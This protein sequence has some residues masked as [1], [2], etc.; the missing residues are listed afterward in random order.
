M[1]MIGLGTER[2]GL[3]YFTNTR[4]ARCQMA[5][6]TFQL[7]HRRLGHLSNKVLSFLSNNVSDICSSDSEQCLVC[8][9]AKQTRIPFPTSQISSTASFE[10]IH[11]DIWGGYRTPSINGACYFLTIVD[12]YTRCTWVYLMQHKSEARSL[13]QSFINLVENQFSTTIKIIRS[14]NGLEFTIPSFYSDKGII[15]QTSCVSTPQQNGV[16]ERKHRHLLNM[17]RALLFQAHLPT[18]FWGDAILTTAYLI[19][20]TPT[21]LLFGKTPY[22]TLHNS[23]PQY[24]HLRVFGCLCFAS[25]HSHNPSKF[26]PRAIRC[27]FLGYPYSQK[28]YRLYNLD[29]HKT[30]ILR[31]VLF[32][33]DHFPFSQTT[34]KPSSPVLPIPFDLPND[35]TTHSSPIVEALVAPSTTQTTHSPPPITR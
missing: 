18:K 20:R 27:V 13:L 35:V 33:E 19:N 6:S 14:D 9:L 21:P 7:W 30:F 29:H 28:G 22:E 3:Y 15:H 31:D 16:V 2:D 10:L 26:A 1:K 4:P 11:I 24:N 8:P 25:T 32:Y 34:P 17:S 12:D 5:K 23:K